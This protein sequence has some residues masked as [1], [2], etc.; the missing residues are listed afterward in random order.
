MLLIGLITNHTTN[1]NAI[2]NPKNVKK[3]FKIVSAIFLKSFRQQ[4]YYSKR[5][6]SNQYKVIR[7]K[8]I[9]CK[10]FTHII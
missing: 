10:R 6:P 3:Y 2:K 5:N 9:I 7:I 8:K 4:Q 1:R